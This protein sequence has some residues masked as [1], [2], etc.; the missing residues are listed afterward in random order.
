M[1][2]RQ[3]PNYS[4]HDREFI[5]LLIVSMLRLVARLLNMGR[6][7]K[8]KPTLLKAH[9]AVAP[10]N[11][12][13]E[14]G[15]IHDLPAFLHQFRNAHIL[16]LGVGSPVGWLCII[17]IPVHLSATGKRNTSATRIDTLLTEPR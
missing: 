2:F 17:I 10:D 16:R 13:I 9:I 7:A 1:N 6:L 11:E 15:D 5:L 4:I 8:T 3:R 14:E 12:V